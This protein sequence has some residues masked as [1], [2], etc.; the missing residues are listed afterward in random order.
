MQ[1]LQEKA[2]RAKSH[3]GWVDMIKRLLLFT[4]ILLLPLF[5][6]AENR[7]TSIKTCQCDH[8][9]VEEGFVL[10]NGREFKKINRYEYFVGE[11]YAQIYPLYQDKNGV[12]AYFEGMIILELNLLTRYDSAISWSVNADSFTTYKDLGITFIEFNDIQKA[13][14]AYQKLRDSKDPNILY[15]EM[16]MVEESVYQ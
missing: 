2:S 4:I 6:V 11:E 10:G 12:V 15:M 16:A 8:N 14:E 5:V 13:E 7:L 1:I 9:E 3:Y